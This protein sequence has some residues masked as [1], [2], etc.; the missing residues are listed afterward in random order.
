MININ[1]HQLYLRKT[2]LGEQNSYC[3]FDIIFADIIQECLNV[4][5]A[6]MIVSKKMT[7]RQWE[8]YLYVSLHLCG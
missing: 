5:S 2:D 1:I 7:A 3:L 6:Y 8:S 4:S